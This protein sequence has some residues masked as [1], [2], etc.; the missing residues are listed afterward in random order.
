MNTEA[1]VRLLEVLSEDAWQ[2]VIEGQAIIMIDDQA[3]ETG[4]A[5]AGNAIIKAADNP[6]ETTDSLKQASLE[7]AADIL[8]NYYLTHPLTLKGFNEQARMLIDTHGSE[9]FIAK[10]GA[11]PRF[12]LFVE[13]GEVVAEPAGS[14]RHRYGV[15]CELD[16]EAH[17]MAASDHVLRWLERGEAHERYLEMNVCRY[18]C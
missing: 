10:A 14:P 18:T 17:S 5:D 7:Q 11:Y 9:A 2:S 16:H 13:V 4:A 6:L 3:L 15:F 1:F 12:T 8:H